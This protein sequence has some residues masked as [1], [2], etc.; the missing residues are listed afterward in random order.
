MSFFKKLYF[1]RHKKEIEEGIFFQIVGTPMRPML[2]MMTKVIVMLGHKGFATPS[3]LAVENDTKIDVI[4]N[5]LGDTENDLEFNSFMGNCIGIAGET[6]KVHGKTF[7]KVVIRGHGKDMY[8]ISASHAVNSL[9]IMG[10]MESGY[11]ISEHLHRM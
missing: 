5:Y 6:V 4:F 1:W 3:F 10:A 9:S 7:R 2:A 11:Y 8:W